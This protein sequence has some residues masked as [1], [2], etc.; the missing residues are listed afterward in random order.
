MALYGYTASQ[1]VDLMKLLTDNATKT[2]CYSAF[3]G[4][5]LRWASSDIQRGVHHER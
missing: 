1:G 4:V 5:I 2:P 3:R